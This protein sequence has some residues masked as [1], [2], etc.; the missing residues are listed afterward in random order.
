MRKGQAKHCPDS[1]NFHSLEEAS[2]WGD[3]SQTGGERK[4]VCRPARGQEF[5]A[6]NRAQCDGSTQKGQTGVEAAARTM[7]LGRKWRMS[8]RRVPL[9][10]GMISGK[11]EGQ[12]RI[13][14]R[15]REDAVEDGASESVCSIQSRGREWDTTRDM[16]L[17]RRVSTLFLVPPSLPFPAL[18]PPP[19]QPAA[20]QHGRVFSQ[21]SI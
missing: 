5:L 7:Y 8:W 15:T 17:A 19:P 20:T 14:R 16:W 10:G 6:R 13:S 21:V 1:T 3:V 4:D 12:R 18:F 11:R 9:L 2:D